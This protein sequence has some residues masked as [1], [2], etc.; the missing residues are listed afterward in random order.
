MHKTSKKL[1]VEVRNKNTHIALKMHFTVFVVDCYSVMNTLLSIQARDQKKTWNL[2]AIILFLP[3]WQSFLYFVPKGKS[4]K[5]LAFHHFFCVVFQSNWIIFNLLTLEGA[6]FFII[7]ETWRSKLTLL[8]YGREV[9]NYD[10]YYDAF[11]V[12]LKRDKEDFWVE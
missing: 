3:L 10:N 9:I 2:P 11:P 1:I 7:F 6:N 5:A 8:A 12:L 4:L